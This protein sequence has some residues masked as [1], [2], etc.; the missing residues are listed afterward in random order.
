MKTKT[1]LE[2]KA[3][4]PVSILLLLT[5][6]AIP[7]SIERSQVRLFA[8]SYL[9]PLK[10]FVFSMTEKIFARKISKQFKQNVNFFSTH[11]VRDAS[12]TAEQNPC[13]KTTRHS[14]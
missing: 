2:L 9:W 14:D 3:K 4:H 7:A 8:N 12:K 6:P 5:F 10:R 13:N 1:E 11:H